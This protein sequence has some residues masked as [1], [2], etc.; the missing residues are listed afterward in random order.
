VERKMNN[1]TVAVT[2]ENMAVAPTMSPPWMNY[3]KELNELFKRDPEVKVEYNK[4][5]HTISI[6][7]ETNTKAEA[8][9]ILLPQEKRFG[10]VAVKIKIIPA[11][12][13]KNMAS[14]FRSAFEG[15]G[16]FKYIDL[17][18]DSTYLVFDNKVV[19]Y[20]S[21]NLADVNRNTSTLYQDIADR[22]FKDTPH[23]GIH[24]CTYDPEKDFQF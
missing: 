24:F 1:E 20:Y 10:N 8:L 15:N 17:D 19:Q 4:E 13:N 23:N 12:D 11:N 6:Y 18:S 5:D 2:A 21:D 22:V 3:Y 9:A 14:I 7:V 16:A